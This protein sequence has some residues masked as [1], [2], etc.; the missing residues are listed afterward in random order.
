MK[1]FGLCFLI[2]AVLLLRAEAKEATV[3]DVRKPIAMQANEKVFQDF[4]LSAGLEDGLKPGMVVEIFR[5]V[6]L[7]DTFQ[8]KSV[9]NLDVPVAKLKIIHAQKG[10]SVA[11]YH[12]GLSR[13]NL[14]IL[15]SNFVM[16]GDKINLASAKMEKNRKSAEN[17]VEEEEAK[18]DDASI[19]P[20]GSVSQASIPAPEISERK[21]VKA[22]PSDEG[23]GVRVGVQ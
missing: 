20:S 3:F 11:R 16:V 2:H 9:G 1:S 8:N 14:P 13:E 23:L 7:Y 21:S 19:A 4:Y 15:E 6:P 5:V 17:S 22:M 12:S 18:M 10:L